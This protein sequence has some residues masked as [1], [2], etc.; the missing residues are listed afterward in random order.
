VLSVIIWGTGTISKPFRK[1]LCNWESTKSRDYQNKGHIGHC[2]NTS[3]SANVKA[4]NIFHVQ[5][6]ITCATIC[7]YPAKSDDDDDNNKA[8]SK[9]CL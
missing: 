3:E 8:S 1:Y 4:Q 5:N 2:T 7:K 6:N 9:M